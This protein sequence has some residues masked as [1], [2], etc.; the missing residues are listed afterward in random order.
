M[1]VRIDLCNNTLRLKDITQPAY[2][3]FVPSNTMKKFTCCFRYTCSVPL[4]ANRR[5]ADLQQ[6]NWQQSQGRV[7]K[8]SGAKSNSRP[9]KK[10]QAW[11]T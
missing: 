8:A 2:R 11:A 3:G 5:K 6:S 10:A 4:I 9:C 7:E 1:E